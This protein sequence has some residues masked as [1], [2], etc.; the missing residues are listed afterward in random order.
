LILIRKVTDIAAVGIEEKNEPQRFEKAFE[1]I[2][3]ED[4]HVFEEPS[5]CAR[6]IRAVVKEG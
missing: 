2:P 6:I 5:E 1:G 4:W 3:K